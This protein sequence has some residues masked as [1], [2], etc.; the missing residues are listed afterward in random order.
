MNR[1]RHADPVLATVSRA[2]VRGV[3]KAAGASAYDALR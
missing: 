3:S 1:R 2:L